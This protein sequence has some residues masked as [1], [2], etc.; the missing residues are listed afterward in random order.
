MWF[1]RPRDGV[2]T[3]RRCVY[4]QM[5]ISTA[6]KRGRERQSAITA[7]SSRLADWTHLCKVRLAFHPGFSN[8]S[9]LM[10][11]RLDLAAKNRYAVI[12]AGGSGTRFWPKS[13]R[14]SPKQFLPITGTRSMLQETVRRLH[15]LFPMQRTL[16]VAGPSLLP[17]I[18]QHL[19]SLPEENLLAEPAARGTA[20]CLA[21]AAEWIAKRDPTALMAVFPADHVIRDKASLH[22]AITRA[23]SVADRHHCLVTFGVTPTYAE[24]GYGYIEV[25]DTVV[26]SPPRVYWASRFREKPDLAT[27]RRYVDRGRFLWNSGM[28]VWRVDVFRQAISR[29]APKIARALQLSGSKGS[30]S[31]R[32]LDVTSVDVSVME[33]ERLVAVVETRF[34]WSDVGNWAAMAELWGKDRNGNASRGAALL[35]DCRD[36]IVCGR[37]RLIA[38]AGVDDLVVVDGGDAILICRQSRAQD[39]RQIVAALAQTRYRRLL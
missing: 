4:A 2:S 18:R 23:F 17:Q 14:S 22:R 37:D 26:S 28:F 10:S 24:T 29:H 32:R 1:A 25:G 5:L 39:V 6:A 31:Y 27:A 12:L 36:T 9:L 15:G 35:I 20:A 8:H 38:L 13:R 34:G 3:R 21:L 7:T 11:K 33:K 19:P 30:A 16:V